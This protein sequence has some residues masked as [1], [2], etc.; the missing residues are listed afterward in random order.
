MMSA[1][2]GSISSPGDSFS[3]RGGGRPLSPTAA[4]AAAAAADDG[5]AA[6][7][8]GAAT[9]TAAAAAA[10]ALT[11]TLPLSL[12]AQQ[13]QQQQ[14][15]QSSS[16]QTNKN[17]TT[18]TAQ[19]IML[20]RD[21][22]DYRVAT[23]NTKNSSPVWRKEKK[24]TKTSPST[25]T[26]TS[27]WFERSLLS[28]FRLSRKNSH[29]DDDDS[30]N[31]GQASHDENGDA[32]DVVEEHKHEH[33]RPLEGGSTH[34]RI[35]PL[36]KN[37]NI[38]KKNSLLEYQGGRQDVVEFAAGRTTA[39][40][41]SKNRI[42]T[43][44]DA[45]ERDCSFFY[46]QEEDDD[47]LQGGGE[48]DDN[49]S[50]R[51]DMDPSISPRRRGRRHRFRT[52]LR[53]QDDPFHPRHAFLYQDAV[54]VLSPS[55]LQ[56]YKTRYKQLNQ[57]DAVM[58]YNDDAE[59]PFEDDVVDGVYNGIAL[60]AA[61]SSH[62]LQLDEHDDTAV[63]A[64]RHRRE[65]SNSSSIVRSDTA[66][67]SSLC[68][69]HHGRLL[70]R[71]P[72]DQVR[73]VMD[74]DLEAGILS[75]EQWRRR[76]EKK[77]ASNMSQQRQQQRHHWNSSSSLTEEAIEEQE[78]EEVELPPLRYVLTVPMD[79]YQKLVKEMSHGITSRSSSSSSSCCCLCSAFLSCF[80]CNIQYKHG[81]EKM[82]I[83]IAIWLLST[84]LIL[85][86]LNTVIVGAGQ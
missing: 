1:V 17:W 78:E 12:S 50:D 36:K 56:E 27:S 76:A 42:L 3:R 40:G 35:V 43:T 69:L 2:D 18:T 49:N 81:D 84:V 51:F 7:A 83:R 15:Q 29:D 47:Q 65:T 10:A 73:L 80:Q 68:Y 44:E 41:S 53:Q 57:V 9:A 54:D 6:T 67:H 24:A 28:S 70:M 45:L 33:Y 59:D 85:L 20:G 60:A 11:A 32:A 8:L 75:V 61:L 66:F 23:A 77:S 74:P 79:L 30:P 31:A 5:T 38:K 34:G 71:L 19:T 62:S 14:Q 52:L 82:D 58:D 63:Y 48:C 86:F 72:N 37:K 22:E 21:G 39:R 16:R 25:A 55:V 46:R 4:A 26:A 13:Q 64:G